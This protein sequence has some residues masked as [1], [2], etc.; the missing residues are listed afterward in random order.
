MTIVQSLLITAAQ[1]RSGIFGLVDKRGPVV[2]APAKAPPGVNKHAR[3]ETQPCRFST[4][5]PGLAG[6]YADLC[7]EH[8][9]EVY[10]CEVR[11][12]GIEGAGEGL[13]ACSAF[14]EGDTID[15]Y[16]G[17]LVPYVTA[18]QKAA[19]KD[20]MRPY[21]FLVDTYIIDAASTQSCSARYANHTT[22]A[23][24]SANCVYRPFKTSLAAATTMVTLETLR[25]IAAGEEL[26]VDYGK[27][28]R[29]VYNAQ[30]H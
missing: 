20:V 5:C 25:P 3:F 10:G 27:H 1:M 16:D 2:L 15:L 23:K 21:G 11:A 24:G 22:H 28:Y 8:A 17:D 18:E 9:V 14:E 13:F 7:D 12:S 6:R 19:E 30:E 29:A 26:F 4:S